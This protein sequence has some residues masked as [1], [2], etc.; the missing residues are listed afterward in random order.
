[1]KTSANK[2]ADIWLFDANALQAGDI[3][4]STTD[5]KASEAIRV[6]TGQFSHAAVCVEPPVFVEA[7]TRTGVR[8]FNVVGLAAKK[9]PM[10]CVMRLR[11]PD[12]QLTAFARTAH[13]YLARRYF[14]EG[15]KRFVPGHPN[16]PNPDRAFFCSQLVATVYAKAGLPLVARLRPEQIHPGHIC[17]SDLLRDVSDEVLIAAKDIPGW[18]A[19]VDEGLKPS[20]HDV[21]METER[22]VSCAVIRKARESPLLDRELN[23]FDRLLARVNATDTDIGTGYG[24]WEHPL[25][26]MMYF[27]GRIWNRPESQF[28]Q[29]AI[30]LDNFLA[31]TLLTSGYLGLPQAFHNESEPRMKIAAAQQPGSPAE[32][33]LLANLVQQQIDHCK[34]TLKSDEGWRETYQ[35][36]SNET[37]LQSRRLF[38]DIRLA[39]LERYRREWQHAE[40]ML[41]ALQTS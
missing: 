40:Q 19:F 21:E 29:A 35:K 30:A 2:P 27:L 12:A 24:L 33:Q 36:W 20:I 7:V 9:R 25:H 31:Q 32:R 41:Q 34:R 10:V 18:F 8:V 14:T 6:V 22:V 28:R 23:E 37:E 38:A 17:K 4:L 26:N 5:A 16:V 13:R 3:L 15:L 11:K 1:M 39:G